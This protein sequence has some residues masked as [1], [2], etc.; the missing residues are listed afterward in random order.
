METIKI[1]E[2]IGFIGSGNMC[3]ALVGGL[4]KK[5]VSTKDKI[6][7]SNPS[8][9][10]LEIMKQK[11]GTE[12]FAGPGSNVE[13]VKKSQVVVLAVKPVYLMGVLN[14]IKDHLTSDHLVLSL[15]AGV[16]IETI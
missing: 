2:T 15:V 14:E 3:E 7:S 12:N 6:C 10:R 13:V 11:F 1:E 16:N 5:E 9:G 4:I 8:T